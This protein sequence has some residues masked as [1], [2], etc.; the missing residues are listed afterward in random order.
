MF[1]LI[2]KYDSIVIFRHLDGDGDALGSQW[3]LYYYLT[4]KY[5][6]KRIYAVGDE[7]KG[8][9]G[10]YPEAHVLSKETYVG[11]LG[12]VV[13]T[14]NKERISGEHY[15]LCDQLIKIDH[16]L[17][18]DNYGNINIVDETKSSCAE[19]VTELLRAENLNVPL[20]LES[21]KNLYS[22]IISDTQ[23]FSIPSVTPETFEAASYLMRS[24]I[25]PSEIS[26]GLRQIDLDI[27]KFQAF[28]SNNIQYVTE[29][30]AYL[31]ITRTQLDKFNIDLQQVKFLVNTMRNIKG[32]KVWTLLIEGEPGVY[33][34][35][36]RSHEVDINQVARQFDGGGHL[37]ASGVKN[38]NDETKKNLLNK[39]QAC[40]EQ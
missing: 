34:A 2:A 11:S 18:V 6:E 8:Y 10:L 14:A 38:L 16:H 32:L 25:N 28:A 23:G 27:F 4:S 36:I 26:L 7:A 39:L 12:I 3:G 40:S 20:P 35:S 21:A 9:A 1:D 33:S 30:F 17:P 24:N 13:D 31:E 5:P 15:H 37:F 22:G 19:I 29:K